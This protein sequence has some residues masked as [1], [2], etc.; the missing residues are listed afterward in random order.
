MDVKYPWLVFALVVVAPLLAWLLLRRPL[1]DDDELPDGLLVAHLERLRSLPRYRAL[2]REQLMWTWVAIGCTLLVV[3]GSIWLAA[4]PM[5]TRVEDEKARPGDLLLCFDVT[6][7]M[8][9]HAVALLAQARSLLGDLDTERVGLYGFQTTTAELLPLTDDHGYAGQFLADAQTAL[10]GN[11]GGVAAASAGDGLVSCAGH[12]DEP[13]AL[14]GRAILL[15]SPN[16][17]APGALHSLIDA[18]DV[19]VRND[20]RVYTAA[21]PGSPGEAEL[22]AASEVTGGQFVP[23]A[24][25]PVVPQV[26]ALEQQRLDPP[27][28]PVRDDA[29]VF[30][31]ILVVVGLFGVIGSGLRGAVR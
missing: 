12:F 22:R 19:A 17:P 4:R 31:T 20:V 29:P 14:R 8:R 9:P 15:L 11:A 16:R 25:Q 18:A 13:S 24:G 3:L 27:P 21:P 1:P 10:A 7:A 28:V 5:A 6:P 23:I 30:P 26:R 2:A